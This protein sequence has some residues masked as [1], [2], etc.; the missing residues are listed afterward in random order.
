M[1]TAR[2]WRYGPAVDYQSTLVS[3]TLEVTNCQVEPVEGVLE[4]I[5]A[6]AETDGAR[7]VVAAT[8]PTSKDQVARA[9]R[10]AGYPA[11]THDGMTTVA[12]RT[13]DTWRH[14]SVLVVPDHVGTGGLADIVAYSTIR[15]GTHIVTDAE[16][17]KTADATLQNTPIM[18]IAGTRPL[19]MLVHTVYAVGEA[20][21]PEQPEPQPVAAPIAAPIAAQPPA[22]VQPAAPAPAPAPTPPPSS[23]PAPAP[24]SPQPPVVSPVPPQ[25]T[26]AP[27]PV[28]Q[29]IKQEGPIKI[30]IDYTIG[31]YGQSQILYALAFMYHTKQHVTAPEKDNA[32]FTAAMDTLHEKVRDIALDNKKANTFVELLLGHT[33]DELTNYAQNIA[34]DIV[35]GPNNNQFLN[36]FFNVAMRCLNY[37]ITNGALVGPNGLTAEQLDSYI[38][39]INEVSYKLNKSRLRNVKGFSHEIP[40]ITKPTG[41]INH[42]L[43]W[44]KTLYTDDNE[45]GR[46]KIWDQLTATANYIT[47]TFKVQLQ[48]SPVNLAPNETLS[49]DKLAK[50]STALFDAIGAEMKR[51]DKDAPLLLTMNNDYDL[52]TITNTKEIF[53]ISSDSEIGSYVWFVKSNK[54]A[55]PITYQNDSK[56]YQVTLHTTLYEATKLMG[57]PGP[58]GKKVYRHK[59]KGGGKGTQ[60]IETENRIHVLV[61]PESIPVTI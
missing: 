29:K 54:T 2:P 19:A 41:T 8:T 51:F 33:T 35:K 7:V 55:Y 16:A 12:I 44:H 28:Q 38:D 11:Y 22:P 15:S 45:K 10:A 6:A 32:K 13:G 59:P 23:S 40:T 52:Y 30:P 4:G 36:F 39:H 61:E 24:P 31:D 25:Q 47:T 21:Q 20:V 49:V 57:D 58:N 42:G 1:P 26:P 48:F 34:T 3:K 53:K 27:P 17:P 5:A 14:H 43:A 60:I 18:T 37:N 56:K 46:K 50:Y 9:A